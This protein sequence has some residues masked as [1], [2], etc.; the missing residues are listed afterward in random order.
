VAVMGGK[1]K[2]SARAAAATKPG[3]Y[4]DG[5]GLWLVVSRSGARKWV[6]RF[7]YCSRV[8]EMG[9]GGHGTTLAQAREKAGEARKVIAA[10]RNRSQAVLLAFIGA[11]YVGFGLQTGTRR[12][13]IAEWTVALGFF[14][15]RSGLQYRPLSFRGWY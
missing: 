6:F 15:A 10:G 9:L 13:I 14:G 1:E 5:R 2:L 12:Q 4:G 3:R 7:T 8:T 11:I